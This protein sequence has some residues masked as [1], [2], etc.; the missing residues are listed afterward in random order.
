MNKIRISIVEYL[1][2]APLIW[3]F[4]RGP[5]RGKYQLAFTVPSRCSDDLRSGAADV[6]I[7]P[8]IEYPR[9]PGLVLL[10]GLAVAS[11][12]RV[13]SLLLIAKS[14]LPALHSIALDCSSR[15]TQALT[16]ILCA[17]HW[18]VSP[19]FLQAE[20]DLNAMLEQADAAVLIGDPALRLAIALEN[21]ATMDSSGAQVCDAA[22]VGVSGACRL[23]IYDMVEQWNR[24]TGLPAVLAVW[25][26]RPEVLD[27]EV[28]ADFSASAQYGQARI[29]EIAS[30]AA[31]KMT[32]P[33]KQLEDY[34][35]YHI[36]YSLDDANLR[37][38][39]RFFNSALRLGL[40]A[41]SAPIAWA[42]SHAP[43]LA[44]SNS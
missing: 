14:P 16:K 31:E 9:I 3:G 42:S 43:E 34:L 38:L 25:A 20:P 11:K 35:R 12:T 39:Q 26:A 22:A 17:E 5:L 6:A 33:Q 37:G 18:H 27:S 2:T 10:P 30:D 40:I 7:I 36:D 32:L 13:R 44:R 4:T 29:S 15:S 21:T 23:Y 8:A 28:I 24:L 1:N 19:E 41:N